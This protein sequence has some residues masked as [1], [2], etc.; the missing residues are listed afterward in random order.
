[1]TEEGY[2]YCSGQIVTLHDFIFSEFNYCQLH[3]GAF[4]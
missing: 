1:M 2:R 4:S 3:D